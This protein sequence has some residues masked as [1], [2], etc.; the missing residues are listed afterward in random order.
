MVDKKSKKALI[1]DDS[2]TAYTVLARMLRNYNIESIHASSGDR[3]LNYLEKHSV[4]VIFLDQAMP[5]KDGFQTIQELKDRDQTQNIPVVMFTARSGDQYVQDAKALGAVGILPKELTPEE[6][7]NTLVQIKLWQAGSEDKLQLEVDR[8]QPSSDEKLRVWL[9]SFLENQFSPQLSDKVRKATDDLRRDTIH[10]GKRMLDE[11]AKTDKQQAMLE[12][13]KGQTDY[14]KQMFHTSF[15]QYRWISFL[16]LI[17]LVFLGGG[18]IWNIVNNQKIQQQNM[19]LV[20]QMEQLNKLLLQTEQSVK[21]I[22]VVTNQQREEDASKTLHS[23]M[24]L[25]SGEDIVAEVIGVDASGRWVSGRSPQ[26]YIF[27]VDESGKINNHKLSLFYMDAECLSTPYTQ[28]L[29]GLVLRVNQQLLGYTELDSNMNNILPLSYL[30][31]G[32]C[33]PYNDDAIALRM[34]LPNSSSVTGVEDLTYQ[35]R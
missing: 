21:D 12:Q 22:M 14:L 24:V 18:L 20:S 6:I 25:L 30:K 32:Q 4:D 3:A 1:V 31:D 9:E 35:I 16:F 19:Q 11:L 33:Q 28:A 13:V 34:I 2:K 29:A 26:G 15:R 17:A 23:I 10:Y 8:R 5:G 27:L 7:E